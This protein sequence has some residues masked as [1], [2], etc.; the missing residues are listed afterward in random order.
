MGIGNFLRAVTGKKVDGWQ[1]VFSALMD[2]E[3]RDLQEAIAYVRADDSYHD[4]FRYGLEGLQSFRAY[5][6]DS[7]S[8]MEPQER[9]QI[10]AYDE[11]WTL[12]LL[13]YLNKKMYGEGDA[14][15][16]L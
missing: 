13:D 2:V 7:L 3:R 6:E 9:A 1:L 15:A 4:A 12:E 16:L 14:G 8:S 11:E 5:Y 10:E